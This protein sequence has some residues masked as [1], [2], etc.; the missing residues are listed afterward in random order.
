MAA[1]LAACEDNTP[2]NKPPEARQRIAPVTMLPNQPTQ[3][4]RLQEYFSDPDDNDTLTYTAQS[5]DP[6]VA[7][8]TVRGAILTITATGPGTV[9]ITVTATDPD[10]VSIAQSFDVTVPDMQ[11][12]F[13][14]QSA[15]DQTYTVGTAIAPLVLPE[16]TGG[17]GRLT[18]SLTPTVPG[19]RFDAA[20]RTLR[21]TPSSARTYAM[22]Y[23]VVD[24]D[25]DDATLR[26]TIEVDRAPVADTQPSFRGQ[27]VS[28]QTYTVGAMIVPLLLP[29]ASGGN[30]V[31]LLSYSLTPEVP[32][33]EF[34]SAARL[35]SGTPTTAAEGTH[36]MTYRVED[37]D[38]DS[39]TLTFTVLVNPAPVADT[40]PSF[41]AQTVPDQTYTVDE[42]IPGLVLPAAA[43]GDGALS[44]TLWPTVPGLTFDPT[45]R[46]LSG[47]PTEA[48]TYALTY[49]VTD[50][51]GDTDTLMFTVTVTEPEPTLSGSK[52]YLIGVGRTQMIARANLD[53]SNYENLVAPQHPT[54]WL[55]AGRMGIALDVDN[56]KMYWTTASDQPVALD[57]PWLFPSVIN[58]ANLDGSDV[59]SIVVLDVD[60]SKTCRFSGGFALD[61]ARGKVYWSSK[62][63]MNQFVYLIQRANLDGSNVE[64]LV[65]HN[66][67]RRQ[68]PTYS[69][70]KRTIALDV[71]GGKMYWIASQGIAISQSRI[72]SHSLRSIR[73]SP[74]LI[75]RANLDGT[76]IEDVVGIDVR[77]SDFDMELDVTRGKMYWSELRTGR[78]KRANLD[79]S[80][81]ETINTRFGGSIALD[82]AKA[83]IYLEDTSHNNKIWVANLDGS[84]EQEIFFVNYEARERLPPGTELVHIADIALELRTTH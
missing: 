76:E 15:A 18:Y 83:K 10:Q 19:L 79:G 44:Y 28:D 52:I 9:T 11:P 3:T 57:L 47:T 39:A 27:T 4:I 25:G 38:G 82:V 42:A 43:G 1:V 37:D 71:A 66:S 60:N 2:T 65:V 31:A 59:E 62:C 32:G 68:D 33:L 51:D 14:T 67:R 21:G 46:T 22:T 40:Q 45:P 29:A 20:T 12:S 30:A 53:G 75:Q 48:G 63:T 61:L 73:D 64:D 23:R 84:Q 13:G 49:T 69:E 26:F 36:A 34:L 70:S 41:D 7:I 81:I 24:S 6:T 17:N 55:Q 58:R 5:G 74:A 50:T 54:A 72:P 78:T 80:A 16:A 35:L 56:G 77:N 8:V